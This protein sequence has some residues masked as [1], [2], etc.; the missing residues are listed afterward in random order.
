MD[1][2]PLPTIWD[3]LVEGLDAS[4]VTKL[5]G[6]VI[7]FVYGPLISEG[8]EPCAN[9]SEYARRFHLQ[10]VVG[11]IKEVRD[12]HLEPLLGDGGPCL[13]GV[14]LEPPLTVLDSLMSEASLMSRLEPSLLY[15]I[16]GDLHLDNILVDPSSPGEFILLDPRGY[17]RGS[18]DYDQGKLLHSVEGLYHIWHKGGASGFSLVS[19]DAAR[20]Y[21][22]TPAKL[23][24]VVACIEIRTWLLDVLARTLVSNYEKDWLLRARFAEACH[25]L[26]LGRFHL[27]NRDGVRAMILVGAYLINQVARELRGSAP[28][29]DLP[30]LLA[31]AA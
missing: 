13:N 26:S 31:R 21:S 30:M 10:R 7:D 9:E 23:D 15:R 3:L 14:Q 16:H 6:A 4:A 18:L 2:V 19:D 28:L 11:R 22:L 12:T 20:Q 1:F 29:P 8:T 25:F 24:L 5:L 27:E 17:A